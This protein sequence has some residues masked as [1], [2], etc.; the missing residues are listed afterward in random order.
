MFDCR[1]EKYLSQKDQET[2]PVQIQAQLNF[3][4]SVR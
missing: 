3:V 1:S 4:D 2:K